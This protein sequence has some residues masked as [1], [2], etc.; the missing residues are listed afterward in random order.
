MPNSPTKGFH[1]RL[2]PAQA[3]MVI[4]GLIL[5][6]ALCIL[7]R[8]G[9]IVNLTFPAGTFAVGLFLYLRYPILYLGFTW[10]IWFLTPWVR[11]LADYQS[12]WTDPSPILLSPYLVTL[13]TI[14]TFVRYLPKSY[15]Q[16]GLPFILCVFGSFYG[17][18]VGVVNAS[19]AGAILSYLGWITPILFG[20]H[21]FIHWRDYPKLK[22]NIQ[23]TFLW[24]VLLTGGYGV[25]Q[26]L[27][28]PEW[29]K[30]W[31]NNAGT[32][33]FGTPEPLGIRVFSTINSPQPFAV[34]MMAGLILLFSNKTP[35]TFP[36]AAF[37]YLSFLL[38][39]ARSAW[40]GWLMGLVVFVPS[41][42][43]RLQM[44]LVITILIMALFVIPLTTIEPFSDVINSRIESL[45]NTKNDTSYNARAEGYNEAMGL[46]VSEFIGRGVGSSLN[47]GGDFGSYDSG[48]LIMLFALGWFGTIPYLGGLLLLFFNIFQSSEASFDPVF[49][50]ARAIAIA[51]FAQ[52]GLNSVQLG[53]FG[54][55]MWGFLGMAMA[56]RKYYS[57]QKE[58]HTF[59]IRK[60]NLH[61]LNTT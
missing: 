56:A 46:A 32:V 37:G 39:L 13:V 34:V 22:Q 57:H 17:F 16:G 41:L 43:P 58:S 9:R 23:R 18:L 24:G 47:I 60:G 1:L 48:V 59:G 26:Y 3:W 2:Q 50:G 25:V 36:A 54:V 49:S 15:Q 7:V 27:V 45:T 4:I 20:F 53:I 30:F 42:K 6:T 55:V 61:P 33:V 21:L 8:A 5:F 19:I 52:I 40:L 35:L 11:R 51:V 29:D 28:A 12:G 44:R 38:S 31:L 10:W 14:I